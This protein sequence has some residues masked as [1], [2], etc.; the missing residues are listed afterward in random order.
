MNDEN[1]QDTLDR[2]NLYIAPL[3]RRFWAYVIDSVLI[4]F[5]IFVINFNTIAELSMQSIKDSTKALQEMPLLALEVYVL[6][7][8]YQGLFTFLYGASLGKM[9]LKIRVISVDLLDSPN[10]LYSFWRA[11]LREVSQVVYFIPFFFAFGDRLKR[12]LYDRA[13]RTIVIYQNR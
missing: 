3:D 1:I 8:L 7:F 11:F 12:T 10:A 2:E 13:S 5:L 6:G 9:A 4:S